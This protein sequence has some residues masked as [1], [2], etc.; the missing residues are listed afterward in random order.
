MPLGSSPEWLQPLQRTWAVLAA[1]CDWAM[2]ELLDQT[3]WV[4]VQLTAVHCG[5]FRQLE[6]DTHALAVQVSPPPQTLPQLPQL[7]ELLVVFSSQPSIF[8]LLLQSPK[9]ALQAPVHTLAVQ[10][11]E[12]MLLLEQTAPQPPQLLALVAVLIS[13]PLARLLSQ[14]AKLGEHAHVLPPGVLVQAMLAPQPPLFTRHSLTS[15][16]VKPSPV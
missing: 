16:Q 13:Q 10:V 15:V 2:P 5:L 7:L 11:G 9:P 6:V 8:L 12:A 1:A 4:V 14:S 3:Q